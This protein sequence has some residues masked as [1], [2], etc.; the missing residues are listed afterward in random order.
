MTP[1]RIQQLSDVVANQIAAGEVIER[2]ASVVKELLENSADAGSDTIH[3]DI[4]FGGLNQIKLS[5]NGSGIMAEDL[6]LAIAA[7]ATSKIKNLQD[8]FAISSMGFRGEALASIASVSRLAISS[9]PALQEHAMRLDIDG[10]MISSSE[11]TARTQGTTVD[12]RDLFFNAPV[13]KRFLK[14]ARSEFQAIELVVKRFALSEPTITLILRHDAK[15]VVTLMGAHCERTRLMRIR[16]IL[17][18]PFVDQAIPIDI[19][20]A[21][22]RLY[23]WISNQT[24]QRSQNDKQWIYINQRMTKDKLLQHAVKRAYENVLHPG[25]YPSCLLYL[26]I[27]T[28]A[29]DVNVH[30]TKHEVR[31]QQPRLV[32]DFIVS[33]LKKTLTNSKTIESQ[34]LA[35]KPSKGVF[36][37]YTPSPLEPLAFES[38]KRHDW[39][40]LNANVGMV[41]FNGQ[42][43]LVDMKRAQE[44]LL[45][46]SLNQLAF[47]LESR[48]L[49]VPV[50][51]TMAT[52]DASYQTALAPLGIE[53]DRIGDNDWVV[54]TIPLFLP[55]LKIKS[56]LDNLE[57]IMTP[58]ANSL[59]MAQ[60]LINYQSFDAY[61]LTEDETAK[62]A[63]YL[64]AKIQNSEL[65]VSWCRCLD[66]ETLED[67]FREATY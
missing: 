32:H 65:S 17:G 28:D 37:V 39:H 15:E 45:L 12:V 19:E 53:L 41:F 24:Y 55:Q 34:S 49:L 22:M 43:Y 56:M 27:P 36:E 23:G 25:R 10:G 11:P 5:D 64:Y 63:S 47:P 16:K 3:L 50:R 48:P 29:V 30:P 62:L 67:F 52:N 20:Q 54:R 4:G 1:S 58:D 38:A 66:S 51:Y 61:Q 40:I 7:H 35:L 60:R 21:G 44:D 14:S 26:S 8:L 9:K 42:A 2:P 6:P 59:L 31:F 57:N 46:S 33:N 18:N 13:R